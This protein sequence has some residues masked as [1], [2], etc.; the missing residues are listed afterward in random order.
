MRFESKPL[1]S[2]F[3][4]F[5]NNLE[6]EHQK[7]PFRSVDPLRKSIKRVEA[8]AA[9]HSLKYQRIRGGVCL[10]NAEVDTVWLAVNSM[11][12][13]TPLVIDVSLPLK[14]PEFTES[15]ALWVSD[16]I[17]TQELEEMASA[18]YFEERILGEFPKTVRYIG[19][20][21]ILHR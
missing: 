14:N 9:Q 21:A 3:S 20:A 8:V 13:E 11:E 10:K 4:D 18:T 17:T 16:D 6:S 15:L 5:I 2:K 19:Q 12:S 7:E 1:P